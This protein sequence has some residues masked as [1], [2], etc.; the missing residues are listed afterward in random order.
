LSK[1]AKLAVSTARRWYEEDLT[2]F[3]FL[4]GRLLSAAFPKFQSKLSHELCEL[5]TNGMGT[6]ADFVLAVMENYRGEPATHEVLKCIVVKFP[7]D[8][9]KLTG[10]GISLDNT[11]VVGGEFGFVD[12]MREKKTAIAPWLTDPRAEVQEFA[13]K[14]IRDLDVRIADEQRR[15]E[16]RKALR[17]LQYDETECDD[18]N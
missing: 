13:R 18:S 3:R 15:A 6:D 11:G 2:L 4:G 10:V 14:H 7:E 16:E 1:D 5:V 9:S 17:Q 12:A 8:E